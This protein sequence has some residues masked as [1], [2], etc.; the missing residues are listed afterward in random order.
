MIR[1]LAPV[2]PLVLAATL[3]VP[4]LA[5]AQRRFP[6]G[7][8]ARRP[9]TKSRSTTSAATSRSTAVD[10]RQGR[11]RRRQARQ[12]PLL[13]SHQG[14][15]AGDVARRR[16]SACSTTTP[17][18][19]ATTAASTRAIAAGTTIA[20][21]RLE[22]RQHES[23]E[24]AVPTNLLVSASSVSGDVHD[25]G[26]ARRRRGE[27]RERRRSARQAARRPAC[28]R[29]GERRRRRA[30]RRIHRHAAISSF[31]SVSGDVT[32]DAAAAASTPTSRCRP[33]A[34]RSTATS[35]SRSADGRMSRRNVDARI[36]DGGRRFDVA[37]VS[38]DLRTSHDPVT[39]SR[40][41][42]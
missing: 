11:S 17:I 27:Q 7:K 29:L 25:D 22:R 13:R 26:R 16:R 42:P 34:A 28:A 41:T 1:R 38:G 30:G 37:T 2:M 32:L 9:A 23:L 33:S 19:I 20:G 8:R 24:V 40:A 5:Q 39:E 6:L 31:H 36:G 18:R 14:R 12:Q 10:D 4:A 21:S 3:A 35:R 15:R